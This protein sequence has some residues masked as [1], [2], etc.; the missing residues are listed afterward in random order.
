VLVLGSPKASETLAIGRAEAVAKEVT[1][2]N[3]RELKA[4]LMWYLNNHRIAH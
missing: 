1:R 2:S 4:D 3:C